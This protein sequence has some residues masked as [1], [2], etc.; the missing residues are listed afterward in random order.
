MVAVCLKELQTCSFIVE[1]VY[2]GETTTRWGHHAHRGKAQLENEARVE[3]AHRRRRL[4]A[5]A[6]E[7]RRCVNEAVENGLF[8]KRQRVA[9]TL[10]FDNSKILILIL[11]SI[12]IL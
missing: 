2:P 10:V 11:F 9:E 8:A 5:N 7:M 3:T 1:I 12:L 6:V 4:S